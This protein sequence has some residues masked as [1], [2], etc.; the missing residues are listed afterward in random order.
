MINYRNILYY[1]FKD[2]SCL[3]HSKEKKEFP[4]F[5]QIN[6]VRRKKKIIINILILKLQKKNMIYHLIISSLMK[7][8]DK[9]QKIKG[10]IFNK[11]WITRILG[12]LLFIK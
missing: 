7:N 4:Y 8:N 6:S 3:L 11:D 5:L 1:E 2:I 9:K 12:R 10:I